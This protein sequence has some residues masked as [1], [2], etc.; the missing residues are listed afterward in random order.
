MHGARCRQSSKGRRR[1]CRRAPGECRHLNRVL[2]LHLLHLEAHA[3][4]FRVSAK[5]LVESSGARGRYGRD[6][7]RHSVFRAGKKR[8]EERRCRLLLRKVACL[9][10]RVS[11]SLLTQLTRT[12]RA[13]CGLG[14]L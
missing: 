13:D 9:L 5:V 2:P 4:H 14:F 6:G 1:R 12:L 3:L 7:S 8:R 10:G 11:C